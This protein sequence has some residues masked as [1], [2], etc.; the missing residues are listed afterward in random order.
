MDVLTPINASEIVGLHTKEARM[1]K[2]TIEDIKPGTWLVT[3][4]PKMVV[5]RRRLICSDGTKGKF[6][7][8][9]DTG[10]QMYGNSPAQELFDFY[11]NDGWR[12]EK[13]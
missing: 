10:H 3:D 9:S 1:R 6:F 12:V 13:R 4:N 8:V 11:S 5:D 2:L 7:V